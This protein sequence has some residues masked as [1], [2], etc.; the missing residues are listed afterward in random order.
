MLHLDLPGNIHSVGFSDCCS[1][2]QAKAGASL[3][4]GSLFRVFEATPS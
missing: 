4:V 2:I 1:Q 3:P